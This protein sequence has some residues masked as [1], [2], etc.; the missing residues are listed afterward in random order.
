MPYVVEYDAVARPSAEALA[1]AAARRD[2]AAVWLK[3][4]D[5]ST[6]MTPEM[7]ERMKRSLA[8]GHPVAIGL[9]WPNRE[10][11]DED[12]RLAM[13]ADGEV[14]DGHSVA[15]VGYRDDATAA[16]GGVF[17]FRNSFGA[18]WREGGHGLMP[19]AYAAAYG[20]DA[21]GV[22]AGGGQPL[23][24]NDGATAP[25]EFE[26]L[27]GTGRE[28]CEATTQDM[29]PWGAALWSGGAQLFCAA[30]EGARLCF[31]LDVPADG[32]Y[33]LNLYATRAPD[34]GI[35]RVSVDG[36]AAGE[37]LDLYGAEVLP[38]GRVALGDFDLAAGEHRVCF[39]VVGK[40]E[41]SAGYHFGLDCLELR[42]RAGQ[43]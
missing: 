41:A 15:L 14:F 27:P 7:L 3:R 16:G 38:S 29:A 26:N 1:E 35:L 42:A 4:W 43:P 12:G 8:E 21:V 31:R 30:A 28:G 39:T 9:R 10:E 22:R 40:N 17:I 32:R 20:N 37:D 24:R 2:V 23:P 13:P 36:G 25:L 6:G 19:Y 18:D 34:Y 5:A 33:A 11:Y